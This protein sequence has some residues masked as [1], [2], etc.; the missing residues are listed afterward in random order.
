MT[1]A[2]RSDGV[3]LWALGVAAAGRGGPLVPA[4]PGLGDA[5]PPG[6]L[7]AVAFSAACSAVAGAGPAALVIGGGVL[8]VAAAGVPGAGREGALAV[9][10]LH[11]V[12]Q[13]VAGLVAARLV[14]VV[15]IGD[16]DRPEF[17]GEFPAVGQGQRPGSVPARRAGAAGRGERPPG[18][19]RRAVP[20]AG[21]RGF[22]PGPGGSCAAVPDGDPGR[23]SHDDAPVA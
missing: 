16:R 4:G 6:L 23:V 14:L 13:R 22:R 18:A 9:A 11:Q 12:P 3:L 21:R 20:G 1:I 15:A 5:P 17:H 8:E 2:G 10:D 7:D 19:G